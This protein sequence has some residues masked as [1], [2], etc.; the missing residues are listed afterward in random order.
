MLTFDNN[1]CAL[2]P[3][4]HVSQVPYPAITLCNPANVDTGEYSRAIFNN[5]KYDK[6]LMH[7]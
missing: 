3:L 5:L 7:M 1:W 2:I 6:V 4:Q